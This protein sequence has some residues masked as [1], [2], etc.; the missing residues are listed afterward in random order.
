MSRLREFFDDWID[1]NTELLDW[2]L[3]VVV[4]LAIVKLFSWMTS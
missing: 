3:Y 1:D 4:L 2:L